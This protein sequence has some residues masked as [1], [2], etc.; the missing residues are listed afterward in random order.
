MK[1]VSDLSIPE[2]VECLRL[3]ARVS[4][5]KCPLFAACVCDEEYK[6]LLLHAANL[7]EKGGGET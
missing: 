1:H 4:C 7:L 2:V 5:E 6:S 3:C